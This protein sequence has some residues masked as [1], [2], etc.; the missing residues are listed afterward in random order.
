MED[1]T[2]RAI[3]IGVSVLIAVATISSVMTYYSTAQDMVRRIGSGTDIAGL[4]DKGIENILLKNTVRGV[5]VKN[6]I[7]YFE[8]KGG[9]KIT[10]KGKYFTDTGISSS[11]SSPIKY[12]FSSGMKNNENDENDVRYQIIPSAQ[13]TIARNLKDGILTIEV[14]GGV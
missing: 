12:D 1:I 14:I 3:I 6:L 8:S 10:F 2:T 5:D 11:S 9:A 4:Y 13:Y 7:N